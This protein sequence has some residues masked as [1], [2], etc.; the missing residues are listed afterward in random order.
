MEKKKHKIKN[1]V[2]EGTLHSKIIAKKTLTLIP[3]AIYTTVGISAIPTF[4]DGQTLIRDD[5]KYYAKI[6]LTRNDKNEEFQSIEYVHPNKVNKDEEKSIITVTYPW[7][8]TLD[9][10]EREVNQYSFE[11]KDFFELND[12]INDKEKALLVKNQLK[13]VDSKTQVASLI[14]D[15]NEVGYEVN[16]VKYDKE[17]YIIAKETAK[18]NEVASSLTMFSVLISNLFG[19]LV[20]SRDFNERSKKQIKELKKQLLALKQEPIKEEKINELTKKR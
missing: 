14:G 19:Q 18:E 8:R 13:K 17:D 20:F 7:E 10:Y 4:M 12:V 16:I 3:Y 11:T 5:L 6:E 15:T 1:L 2:I 9:G